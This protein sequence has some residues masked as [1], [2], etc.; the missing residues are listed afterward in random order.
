MKKSV[1]GLLCLI[2]FSGCDTTDTENSVY[3]E[4]LQFDVVKLDDELLSESDLLHLK[5]SNK[6]LAKLSHDDKKEIYLSLLERRNALLHSKYKEQLSKVSF[7]DQEIKSYYEQNLE[8]FQKRKLILSHVL[9]RK[10]GKEFESSATNV[11]TLIKA[12]TITF[13]QAVDQYSDDPLSKSKNGTIGLVDESNNLFFEIF[14]QVKD[15]PEGIVPSIVLTSDGAHIVRIDQIILVEPPPYK[16]LKPRIEY[17][18]K[19]KYIEEKIEELDA[20]Q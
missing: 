6:I 17:K 9:F 1:F 15:L 8:E 14:S 13:E 20:P 5:R 11:L 2:I 10:D 16:T 7:S 3:H 12:G 4:A 18:L 19:K